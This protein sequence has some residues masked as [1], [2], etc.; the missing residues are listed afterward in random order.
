MGHALWS[1]GPVQGCSDK[2][3]FMSV[4]GHYNGTRPY[5]IMNGSPS[6]ASIVQFTY[7]THHYA[8]YTLNELWI[9]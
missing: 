3:Q 6:N 8:Y 9:S 2:Q 5:R 4:S 7:E 1:G